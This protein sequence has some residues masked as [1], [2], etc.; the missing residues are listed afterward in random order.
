[1]L[2][3]NQKMDEVLQW[4]NRQG[5]VFHQENFTLTYRENR[6]KEKMENGEGKKENCE[7]E[8]WKCKREGERS[9]KSA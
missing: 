8:G 6:G 5:D 3:T 1:M 2:G 7:R 9:M 4:Q